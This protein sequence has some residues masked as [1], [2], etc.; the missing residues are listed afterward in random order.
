MVNIVNDSRE[1]ISSRCGNNYLSSACLNVSRCFLLGCIE[2]CTLKNYVYTDLS[3][4]KLLSV[5][6]CINLDLFPIND[7]RILGRLYLV[8]QS[9]FALRRIIL[10]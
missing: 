10:E 5:S 6:L 1:I 4:W 9:I 2:T 3:P 7:D 8:S